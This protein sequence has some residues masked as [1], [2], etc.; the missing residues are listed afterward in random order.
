MDLFPNWLAD[1]FPKLRQSNRPETIQRSKN[2]TFARLGIFAAIT[3]SLAFSPLVHAADFG[4]PEKIT[5]SFSAF[6]GDSLKLKG[7]DASF[8]SEVQLVKVLPNFVDR[9]L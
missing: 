6:E 7:I 9:V 4:D 8:K 1:R 5:L 2:M 3:T